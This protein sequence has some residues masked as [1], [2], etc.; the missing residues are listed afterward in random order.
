MNVFTREDV[1]KLAELL[2]WYVKEDDVQE[3]DPANAYWTSKK[4]EAVELLRKIGALEAD[5]E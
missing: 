2:K 1:E 5:D 3:H 4:R